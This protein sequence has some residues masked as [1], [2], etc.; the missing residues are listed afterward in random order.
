MIS[1]FESPFQSTSW[2]ALKGCPTVAVNRGE[3]CARAVAELHDDVPFHGPLYRPVCDHVIESI[4][5]D[6]TGDDPELGYTVSGAMSEGFK[7]KK[8]LAGTGTDTMGIGI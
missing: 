1:I 3:E 4:A 6:V 8:A 2:T 5:I 7:S